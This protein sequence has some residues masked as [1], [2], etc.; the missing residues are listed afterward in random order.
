MNAR[1]DDFAVRYHWQEGSVPP[2]DHYHYTL[3]LGP[4]PAGELAYQPDYARFNP[5]VWV[6]AIPITAAELDRLYAWVTEASLAR[7]RWTPVVA[8]PVGGPLEWA[9]LTLA[10]ETRAIPAVL[11]ERERAL[12][13]PFY[14]AVRALA[15]PE[16]WQALD[17]RRQ[18]YAAEHGG[19]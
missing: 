10:G 19:R 9:V 6:A 3:T 4:G 17:A 15:A 14:A 5:P 11:T 12:V 13:A 7:A 8:P 1:P 18:A 2:P 16:V